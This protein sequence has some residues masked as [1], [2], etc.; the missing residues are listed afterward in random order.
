M[1]GAQLLGQLQGYK[2]DFD[3]FSNLMEDHRPEPL[4]EETTNKVEVETKVT[5][6]RKLSTDAE[7]AMVRKMSSE[8]A[9]SHVVSQ[10]F[11]VCCPVSTH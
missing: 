9:W 10:V 4:E 1:I 11:K 2:S 5:V 6:E 3:K 7:I 8:D